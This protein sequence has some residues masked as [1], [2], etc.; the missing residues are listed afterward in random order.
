MFTKGMS[1]SRIKVES[2]VEQGQAGMKTSLIKIHR[3]EGALRFFY[4]KR[5]AL[6]LILALQSNHACRCDPCSNWYQMGGRPNGR[7]VRIKMSDN[8]SKW[9]CREIV[10]EKMQ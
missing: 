8:G 4:S 3:K 1:G 10:D 9:S 2:G 6:V 7:V 5:K